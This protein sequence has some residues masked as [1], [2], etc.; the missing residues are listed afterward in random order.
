MSAF[1]PGDGTVLL[2]VPG[3]DAFVFRETDQIDDY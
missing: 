3:Y 1:H 2:R